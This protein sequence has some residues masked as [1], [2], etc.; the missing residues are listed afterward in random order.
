MMHCS[1][2]SWVQSTAKSHKAWR[3]YRITYLATTGQLQRRWAD[4]A[5]GGTRRCWIKA[6]A[7][8][9]DG[10]V[11]TRTD[12]VNA[13]AET[14]SYDGLNRLTDWN[15]SYTCLTGVCRA[16]RPWSM[17][18]ELR[19]RHDRQPA[20]GDAQWAGGGEQQLWGCQW[21]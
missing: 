18:R 6:Y 17:R 14:F 8:Y 9:P 5:G 1:R 3:S 21:R 7:Y 11:Q 16:T 13:R 15:L 4:R 19:V 12:A 10:Q 2:A 20:T